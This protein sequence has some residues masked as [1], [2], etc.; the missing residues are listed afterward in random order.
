MAESN[1]WR[2]ERKAMLEVLKYQTERS[3]KNIAK[4]FKTTGESFDDTFSTEFFR[5]ID[6]T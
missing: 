5:M 4:C 1:D 2:K 3:L 6:H